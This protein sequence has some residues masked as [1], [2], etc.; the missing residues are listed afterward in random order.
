MAGGRDGWHGWETGHTE[1][2]I[3]PVSKR[4]EDYDRVLTAAEGVYKHRKV[5][6]LEKALRYW[7]GIGDVGL[8]LCFKM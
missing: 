6:W 3:R 2:F 1:P 4:T 8:N 5:G 7:V